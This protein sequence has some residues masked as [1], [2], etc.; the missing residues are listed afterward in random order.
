TFNFGD[1]G[2]LTIKIGNLF[3]KSYNHPGVGQGNSG[4]Y[5]YERSLLNHPAAWKNV[6]AEYDSDFLIKA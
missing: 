2:Y 4:N 5:Y 3:N 6:Y 1:Y